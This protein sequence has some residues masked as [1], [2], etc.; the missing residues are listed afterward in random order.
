VN[1]DAMLRNHR[2]A[3]AWSLLLMAGAVAALF[4]VGRH[5]ED[6][7]PA[8]TVPAIGDFDASVHTWMAEIRATPLTWLARALSIIGSGVV[9]IPLRAGATVLLLWRRRIRQAVAFVLTWISAELLI[10]FLKDWFHRGRPTGALVETVGYSF[11][12]GHAVAASATAV[13]LVLALFPPGER[14]RRWELGA[15]A[16]SFVM[17][18]SRVYLSA[19]WFSD[20][21]AGT[22]LGTGLAIFWAAA[23][24]EIRDV[25]FRS[26]GRPIPPDEAEPEPEELFRT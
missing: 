18:F 10:V 9:T 8:T 7:A 23:V 21:V 17:A 5:P 22:L 11:P 19:H 3:F 16:F 14:R 25:I 6:L 13:A 20:V 15:V 1:A 24:T 12:S 4:L 26:E 2:R